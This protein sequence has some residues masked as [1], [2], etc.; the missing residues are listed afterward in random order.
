MSRYPLV[1]L[2]LCLALAVPVPAAAPLWSHDSTAPV[3]AVALS[4]NG[5]VVAVSSNVFHVFDRNGTLLGAS[6][7]AR[8]I[9]VALSGEPVVAGTD[10]TVYAFARNGTGLWEASNGTAALA[11]SGDGGTVAVLGPGGE[12]GVYDTDGALVGSASADAK[13][14]GVDVAVSKT[15]SVI[16]AAFERGVRAFGPSGGQTWA[17][18][19]PSPYAVA[20]N[21]SGAMVAVGD[22]GSVTL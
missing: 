10:D 12:L 2:L 5:S 19:Q 6:F 9:G 7:S 18:D 21:A 20:V 13:G 8:D 4:A 3:R 17:A 15:G 22:G 14:G 16:A 11:V 1:A